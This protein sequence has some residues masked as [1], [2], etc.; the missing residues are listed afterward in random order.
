DIEIIAPTTKESRIL[1][2]HLFIINAICELIDY[3]LF[4]HS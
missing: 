3:S 1:E 2:Q 4:S